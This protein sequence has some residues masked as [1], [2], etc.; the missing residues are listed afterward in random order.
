MCQSQLS[1]FCKKLKGY[2][3]ANF[4]YVYE[5]IESNADSDPYWYQV[6]MSLEKVLI[7]VNFYSTAARVVKYLLVCISKFVETDG[8]K[9]NLSFSSQY[10]NLF[11]VD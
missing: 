1:T 8:R 11:I 5:Q 6:Y 4:Q 2:L 3:E 10:C 9:H 7:V